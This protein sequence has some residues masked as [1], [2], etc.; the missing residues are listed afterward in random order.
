M[1]NHRKIIIL[2]VS[3]FLTIG[4]RSG[5]ESFT[6]VLSPDELPMSS[7]PGELLLTDSPSA[8]NGDKA[9]Q[10]TET[11][12]L[13]ATDSANEASATS[14]AV[15]NSV[16]DEVGIRETESP[17]I[18][19]VSSASDLTDST[20]EIAEPLSLVTVV[21]SVHR[22]YPLVRG[23]FLQRNIAD[24]R[25]LSAWGEFDT[26]LKAASE[27]G[28]IGFYE[29]YRNSLSV[30]KPIYS[31]GE[32]YA[33]FRN[34]AGQFQP[35]YKERET[36]DGGEFKTGV[37][38]PLIRD[39]SIDSRRAAVWRATYGQQIAN[40][41]IRTSL[42]MFSREASLA[43]WKWVSTGQKYRIGLA[44]LELARS[45]NS[46]IERRV[47][48][49]DLDPPELTDNRRAIAKREAKLAQSLRD[50]Q[51]AAAK[52]SLFLRDENGNPVEPT[53]MMLP[54]FPELIEVDESRLA[55]DIASARQAR[56]E[57]QALN[58]QIRQLQ[59][60]Y[61][62]AC[63]DTLPGL[64]AEVNGSQDVG[65]PASSKRDKSEFELEAGLY[66]DMPIERRK[67]R[68][69]MHA[70]EAKI[71]QVIAKRRII[72]DKIA[73]DLQA[74]YAGLIQSYNEA[75]KSRSSSSACRRTFGSRKEEV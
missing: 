73:L 44:W 12:Q 74:A 14:T 39:R 48:L 63:N 53:D 32:F 7:V 27:N 8:P 47:Q 55:A 52:L 42:I 51:Q 29:T 6:V 11:A 19:Q 59:V 28:P 58:L 75:Q 36:D 43:Y 38:L 24:G 60:E 21:D 3:A 67:G 56:P 15:F 17:E 71:A 54:E 31:G 69:K 20:V 70:T 40:P 37:R 33:G 45:R 34:G 4:C 2:I 9:A 18:L 62:A 10:H 30:T 16:S 22:S 64:Y 1:N 26:K 49:K 65:T 66:F 23:A 46:R 41:E 13:T 57:L 5:K 61:S 50:Y 35:W 25:Q 68:G 72:E